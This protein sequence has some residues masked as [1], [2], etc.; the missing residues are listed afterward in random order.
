MTAP[1]IDLNAKR[2]ALGLDIPKQ[3][4]GM[5]PVDDLSFMKRNKRADRDHDYWAVKPTG[6][7]K[8]D[9]ETGKRLAK[10]FLT[11]I[12]EY[13]CV[14]NGMLLS[15][16]VETMHKK[17]KDGQEWSVVNRAFLDCVN[18]YA[19]AAATVLEGVQLGC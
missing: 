1:V 9:N 14:R 4:F 5:S 19:Q 3:P 2:Y 15:S 18:S 16:I 11:Y 7:F 17:A 6:Q 12:G 13:P 10:E 8:E